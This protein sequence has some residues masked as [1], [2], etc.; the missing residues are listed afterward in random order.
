MSSPIPSPDSS[1]SPSYADI[2]RNES[3]EENDPLEPEKSL[4]KEERSSPCR[5][6]SV[7][8]SIS[9]TI[10]SNATSLTPPSFSP[11]SWVEIVNTP[12]A[13]SKH[14]ETETNVQFRSIFTS[15][16]VNRS[17]YS[18]MSIPGEEEEDD[19]DMLSELISE[20]RDRSPSV[21]SLLEEMD[22]TP[23]TKG[24]KDAKLNQL[25]S[26]S[27]TASLSEEFFHKAIFVKK[28]K[29]FIE[30]AMNAAKEERDINPEVQEQLFQVL[31]LTEK[32]KTSF[33]K[34]LVLPGLSLQGEVV[35]KKGNKIKHGISFFR[36]KV[37][38]ITLKKLFST[39]YEQKSNFKIED[40]KKLLFIPENE[41]R[42][43]VDRISNY[44]TREIIK[45]IFLNEGNSHLGSFRNAIR[46]VIKEYY[47]SELSLFLFK[48]DTPRNS[49]S[50]LEEAEPRVLTFKRGE[51]CDRVDNL[52]K[53][54]FSQ[55]SVSGNIR[56]NE[57]EASLGDFAKSVKRN[58]WNREF[59]ILTVKRK[60]SRGM[61]Y[62][63]TLDNRR[64]C[65]II[66]AC[67]EKKIDDVRVFT[68]AVRGDLP[69]GQSALKLQKR[70]YEIFSHYLDNN[71]SS[72]FSIQFDSDKEKKEYL[73]LMKWEQLVALRQSTFSQDSEKIVQQMKQGYEKL[74]NVVEPDDLY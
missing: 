14:Q 22:T 55:A 24:A 9:P 71:E 44:E 4:S 70:A 61:E 1:S 2:L 17:T 57:G 15:E 11:I 32:K 10:E 62:E 46:E 39:I 25:S 66:S 38:L 40:L 30:E 63:E 49:S 23:L 41:K 69:I 68:S 56:T 12:K 73:K 31:K 72:E 16:K 36:S 18:G 53:L 35:K 60:D 51:M 42:E 65:A 28:L 19:P 52:M 74:P 29:P 34:L 58:G 6:A 3:P 33:L 54:R 21:D 67:K 50:L 5:V 48:V 37:F 26:L 27:K 59:T 13:K 8:E 7:W 20:G 45:G 47:S 43:F 64:A